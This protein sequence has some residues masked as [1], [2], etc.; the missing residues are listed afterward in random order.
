LIKANENMVLIFLVLF[1]DVFDLDGDGM[2]S[3][4]QPR[5]LLVAVFAMLMGLIGCSGSNGS[6]GAPGLHR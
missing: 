4:L 2:R 6:S 3:T 5:Q 1:N